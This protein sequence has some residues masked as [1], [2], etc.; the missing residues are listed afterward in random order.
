MECGYLPV[1]ELFSRA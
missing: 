1:V